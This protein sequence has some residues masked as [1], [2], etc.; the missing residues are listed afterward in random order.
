MHTGAFFPKQIHLRLAKVPD[1]HI[2]AGD[3]IQAAARRR[4]I[5]AG[6]AG[7]R[8]GLTRRV[9]E[10]ES[11]ESKQVRLVVKDA[12]GLAARVRTAWTGDFTIL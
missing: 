6:G 2:G 10:P 8:A 1:A 7:K 9:V 12:T 11:D 3:T 5:A 4:E